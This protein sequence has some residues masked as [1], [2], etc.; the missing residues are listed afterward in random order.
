MAR[1]ELS[2]DDIDIGLEFSTD[3]ERQAWYS[4]LSNQ[5]GAAYRVGLVLCSPAPNGQYGLSIVLRSCQGQVPKP[6]GAP[7]TGE[8]RVRTMTRDE[9]MALLHWYGYRDPLGH[10]L[11]HCQDFIDLVE[12]ACAETAEEPCETLHGCAVEVAPDDALLEGDGPLVNVAIHPN[13]DIFI[14]I[15]KG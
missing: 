1:V 7:Y 9:I 13:G 2:G 8:H 12:R 15:V 10:D 14:N 11:I 4:R 5:A 3:R 6:E